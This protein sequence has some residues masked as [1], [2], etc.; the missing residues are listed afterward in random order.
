MGLGSGVT[1]VSDGP[2]TINDY[3]TVIV[4]VLGCSSASSNMG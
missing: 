4:G 1:I 3:A 2:T